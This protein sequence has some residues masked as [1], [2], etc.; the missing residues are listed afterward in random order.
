[1]YNCKLKTCYA[2]IESLTGVA[3]AKGDGAQQRI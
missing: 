3:D 1:M 2:K